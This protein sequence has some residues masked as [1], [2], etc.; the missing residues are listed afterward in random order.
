MNLPLCTNLSSLHKFS[1]DILLLLYQC[2]FFFKR[3]APKPY[4]ISH[5]PQEFIKIFAQCK[6]YPIFIS[7]EYDSISKLYWVYNFWNLGT[8]PML[9]NNIKNPQETKCPSI[10]KGPI[11]TY[12]TFLGNQQTITKL[13]NCTKT[14]QPIGRAS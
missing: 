10:K 1:H 14:C 2:F 12:K 9:L 8:F 4:L 7:Q 5:F 13:R 11:S 3:K 6:D